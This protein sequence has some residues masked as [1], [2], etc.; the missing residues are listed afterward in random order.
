MIDGA[1]IIKIIPP[2]VTT[3]VGYVVASK[4]S[5][6]HS[7]KIL[8]DMQV[9]AIEQISKAEE[10]MRAEIWKELQLVRDKNDSLER[11]ITIL[12]NNLNA[13][14]NIAEALKS[15]VSALRG[16]VDTYKQKIAELEKK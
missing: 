15:E 11:E 3:L 8:S 12:R 14:N 9:Q 16:L 4:R 2:L 5:R 1:V 13:S 6:I 10:K 7:A